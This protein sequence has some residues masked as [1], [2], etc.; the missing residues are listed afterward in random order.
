MKRKLLFVMLTCALS[1]GVEAQQ[2]KI[3]TVAVSILDRMSSVIGNLHSC[4]VNIKTDYD[5]NNKEL[6]LVKHSDEQQ[7]YIQ[8]NSKLLVHSE[9]D[10]GSR[11]LMYNG[12]T[13]TYYSFDKNHYGQVDAKLSVMDMID[14]VNKNYGIEFPIADFFYASFVDDIIAESKSLSFLGMTKVNGKECFHIAG[15][16][17]DKTF[18]FWISN[19][20]FYLPMKMVIVYNGKENNP[21]YEATLSNWQINPDL[22]E[23]IFD[24]VAPPK[25][26]LIKLHTPNSHK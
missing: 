6:G 13:F 2:S 10:K 7:M 3:D 1:I 25:A 14:T 19:D 21:Q 16:A 15:A 22:P 24:F 8:G 18:Q 26:K 9:G 23:A 12:Q 20:A 11:D 17:K 4:S 5:I